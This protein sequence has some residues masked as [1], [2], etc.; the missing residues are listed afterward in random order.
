MY[1]K[2]CNAKQKTLWLHEILTTIITTAAAAALRR[3]SASPARTRLA[4][5]VS[6]LTSTTPSPQTT[7]PRVLLSGRVRGVM[8]DG[9]IRFFVPFCP[10]DGVC[11]RQSRLL[12]DL[13]DFYETCMT[14][15]QIVAFWVE[16]SCGLCCFSEIFRL[17]YIPSWR[18]T[19]SKVLTAA[20][21]S[22]RTV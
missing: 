6:L 18:T 21:I 10:S 17:M 4:M 5:P 11:N 1:C 16:W 8:D 2:A 22:C 15:I 7:S 19:M 12:I 14:R 3:S 13:I 9:S 20:S